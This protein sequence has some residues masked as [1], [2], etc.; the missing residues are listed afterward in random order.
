MQNSTFNGEVNTQQ[1]LP[2]VMGDEL[3]RNFESDFKNISIATW[4]Y[5]HILAY[6][7][8]K[9]SKSGNYMEPQII[10]MLS[11]QMLEGTGSALNDNHAILLSSFTSKALF[12][13]KS[14]LNKH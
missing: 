5:D 9:I 11:L 14:P 10:D 1:A 3:R 8:N 6:G 2:Y 4:T 13:N 12:G 7:E